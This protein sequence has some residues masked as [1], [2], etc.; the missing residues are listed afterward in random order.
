[1]RWCPHGSCRRSHRY[2]AP[3]P[4][5]AVLRT[6]PAPR[7]QEMRATETAVRDDVASARLNARTGT[8]L[9]GES[10][11]PRWSDWMH[12]PI[13][14]SPCSEGLNVWRGREA[15]P[16]FGIRA[17]LPGTRQWPRALVSSRYSGGTAPDSV[18]YTHLT[19]TTSNQV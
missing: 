15:S 7:S 3:A 19:L 2:R 4:R 1:M 13:A 17:R 9:R 18:T 6:T 16:G 11:R 5:D 8:C 12:A 14:T 10:A